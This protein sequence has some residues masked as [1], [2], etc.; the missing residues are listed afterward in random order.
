MGKEDD[1][2]IE[3]PECKCAFVNVDILKRHIKTDHEVYLK[4]ENFSFVSVEETYLPKFCF[5]I[6]CVGTILK[7]LHHF[8]M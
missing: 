6:I 8:I 4:I 7:L 2:K 1:G 5:Y 3:C